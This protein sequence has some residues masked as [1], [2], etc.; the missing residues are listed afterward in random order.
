MVRLDVE[1]TSMERSSF[2][3]H[4]AS[5]G[6]TYGEHFRSASKSSAS[7]I[8]GG[9]AC[10]VHTIFAFMFVSTASSTIRKLYDRITHRTSATV[11]ESRN[12]SLPSVQTSPESEVG[13]ED[14]D[15]KTRSCRWLGT[16]LVISICAERWSPDA[17]QC[18][19][20]AFANQH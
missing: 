6:E 18:S 10:L 17:N 8:S 11:G 4:P 16:F 5:V 13:G 3:Q 14:D 19:I 9:L 2:T 1:E 20:T 12:L 15:V 7:M